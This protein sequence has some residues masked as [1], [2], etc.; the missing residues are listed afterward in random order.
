M[1]LELVKT[2]SLVAHRET[3]VVF[4]VRNVRD[5]MGRKLAKLACIAGEATYWLEE[6]TFRPVNRTENNLAMAGL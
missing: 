2:G 4:Q 3:G 5:M 6:N 1:K